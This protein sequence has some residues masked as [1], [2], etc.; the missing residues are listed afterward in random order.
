MHDTEQ[1]YNYDSTILQRASIHNTSIYMHACMPARRLGDGKTSHKCCRSDPDPP[2]HDHAC[3]WTCMQFSK[4]VGSYITSHLE[5]A[6]N[7][8]AGSGGP[9]ATYITDNYSLALKIPTEYP[10]L[11][12]VCISHLVFIFLKRSSAHKWMYY[13]YNASRVIKSKQHYWCKG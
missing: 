6:S 12:P 7:T 1:L 10:K 11:V 8:K 5:S 2:M 3:E 13:H 4:L 9:H